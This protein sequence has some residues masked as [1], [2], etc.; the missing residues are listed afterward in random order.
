MKIENF[1]LG[2]VGTNCY[3][4]ANEKAKECFIVDPAPRPITIDRTIAF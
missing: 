2:P 3:I 4:A 1:V